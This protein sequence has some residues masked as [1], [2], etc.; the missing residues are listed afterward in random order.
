VPIAFHVDYWNYLGWSDPFSKAEYSQRQRNYARFNNL[1]TVY[2]PGFLINGQ[3]WR[4]WFRSRMLNLGLGDEVGRLD[5]TIKNGVVEARFHPSKPITGP[6][7]LNVAWLG[8]DIVSEVKSGENEGKSLK[9]D[10]VSHETN[11][12]KGDEDEGVY[13]WQLNMDKSVVSL[14]GRKA[15]AFWVTNSDNPTPIQATGGWL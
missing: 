7:T 10:F 9:H 8:F 12:F 4:G 1:R 13:H 2:T 14:S 11:A 6:L 3:E 15:A 5:V